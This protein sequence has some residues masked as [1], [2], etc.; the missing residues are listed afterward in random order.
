ARG[1]ARS[2]EEVATYIDLRKL[3]SIKEPLDKIKDDPPIDTPE[4]PEEEEPRDWV[5]VAGGGVL[6]SIRRVPGR[7]RGVRCRAPINGVR[8]AP[9]FTPE[10]TVVT[11]AAGITLYRFKPAALPG[12]VSPCRQASTERPSQSAPTH[13]WMFEVTPAPAQPFDRSLLPHHM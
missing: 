1:T 3:R 8:R 13:V 10:S 6:K 9:A 12:E 7:C 11:C 4:E 2:Y 5:P